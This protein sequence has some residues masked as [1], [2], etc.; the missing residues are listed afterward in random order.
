MG[1]KRSIRAHESDRFCEF[2]TVLVRTKEER[3][4]FEVIEEES[5]RERES[6]R[7]RT[8]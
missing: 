2:V 4:F 5:E 6:K 1:T 3:S 8:I 7:E